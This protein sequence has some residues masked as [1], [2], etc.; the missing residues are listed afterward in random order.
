MMELH[1]GMEKLLLGGFLLL[2]EVYV[3]YKKHI[4]ISVGL[5]ELVL[6]F[7]AAEGGYELICKGFRCHIDDVHV[8]VPLKDVVAYGL[9]KVCLSQSYSSIDEAGVERIVARIHCNY[10]GSLVGDVR[11]VSLDKVV[12]S[13]L[14]IECRVLFCVL[15]LPVAFGGDFLIFRR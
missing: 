4:R 13:V 2:K 10:L 15:C 1:E 11:V 8:R 14:C 3:I 5:L 9:E 6:G 12:Q 7:I